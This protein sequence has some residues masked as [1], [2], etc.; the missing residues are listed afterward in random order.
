MVT[1]GRS[2]ID[3]MVTRHQIRVSSNE[4]NLH[5]IFNSPLLFVPAEVV[6]LEALSLA[7]HDEKDARPALF[8]R[9][10][11]GMGVQVVA[12]PSSSSDPL[13]AIAL[14]PLLAGS[15]SWLPS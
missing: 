10:A 1:E 8:L 2:T 3:N 7:D 12:A 9:P 4:H 5:L 11:E 15:L 6:K 14:P 13:K